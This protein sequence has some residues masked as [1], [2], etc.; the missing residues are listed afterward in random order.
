MWHPVWVAREQQFAYVTTLGRKTGRPHTV[1]IWFVRAGDSVYLL[2]G[3]GRGADWVRNLIANSNA[4][5]LLGERE[6]FAR[7]RLVSP[8]AEEESR[9]RKMF[10]DKYS[11]DDLEHWNK[12]A[13]PVALD[14]LLMERRSANRS[15]VARVRDLARNA[16]TP[17]KPASTPL[18]RARQL[19]AHRL[20]GHKFT[21]AHAMEL[22]LAE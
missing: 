7:G 15:A 18:E 16:E 1:E 12:W 13:Q 11:S 20:D 4:H 9:V 8:G 21:P 6:Y 14:L 2:S 17:E 10:A 19:A 3:G 22:A 5:L